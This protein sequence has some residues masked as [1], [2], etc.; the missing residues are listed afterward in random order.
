MICA[1]VSAGSTPSDT[2]WFA[3][4][5]SQISFSNLSFQR[6]KSGML[7]QLFVSLLVTRSAKIAEVFIG[8]EKVPQNGTPG[9]RG[10]LLKSVKA[11]QMRRVLFIRQ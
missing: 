2:P 3:E 11:N 5:T 4:N 10:F 8:C 6:T 7:L 1:A 9:E